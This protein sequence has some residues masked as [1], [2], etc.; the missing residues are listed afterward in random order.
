L[1]EPHAAFSFFS[2]LKKSQKRLSF[3]PEQNFYPTEERKKGG[4]GSVEQGRIA[5]FFFAVVDA[6]WVGG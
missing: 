5:F 3:P 1:D 2:S 6:W 4:S